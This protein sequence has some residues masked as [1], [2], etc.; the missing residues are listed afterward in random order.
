[1]MTNGAA[2][3]CGPDYNAVLEVVGV[4]THDDLMNV[5]HKATSTQAPDRNVHYKFT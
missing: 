5:S 3:H 4:S 1:M 2:I